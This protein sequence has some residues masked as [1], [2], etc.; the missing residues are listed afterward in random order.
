MSV[1]GKKTLKQLWRGIRKHTPVGANRHPDGHTGN[2]HGNSMTKM[3][4]WDRFSEN[5]LY[6][7]GKES[8]KLTIFG[9]SFSWLSLFVLIFLSKKPY[10]HMTQ[11]LLTLWQYCKSFMASAC[12]LEGR[13]KNPN[14]IQCHVPIICGWLKYFHVMCKAMGKL[15][16]WHYH[17]VTLSCF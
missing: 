4:L 16:V 12:T 9:C 17:P 7:L 14:K 3:S 15:N 10:G 1:I 8:Q 11:T 13:R 2:R 5:L 6:K